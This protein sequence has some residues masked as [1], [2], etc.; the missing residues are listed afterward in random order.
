MWFMLTAYRIVPADGERIFHIVPPSVCPAL[1]G[2]MVRPW[3]F[4]TKREMGDD[5]RGR[6]GRETYPGDESAGSNAMC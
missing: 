6:T 2:V 3:H 4:P 5:E 1:N